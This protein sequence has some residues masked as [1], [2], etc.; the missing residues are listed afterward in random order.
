MQEQVK[1][2]A[3]DH[4]CTD[5]LRHSFSESEGDD[6]RIREDVWICRVCGDVFTEDDLKRARH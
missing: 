3:P 4:D 6:G 5:T 1:G 2:H